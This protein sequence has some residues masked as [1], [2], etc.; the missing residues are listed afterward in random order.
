MS[1]RH[2]NWILQWGVSVS[3]LPQVVISSRLNKWVLTF[4]FRP[5]TS[6]VI[7]LKGEAWLHTWGARTPRLTRRVA[8]WVTRGL[9]GQELRRWAGSGSITSAGIT[10]LNRGPA[11]LVRP[12]QFDYTRWGYPL[13]GVRSHP[14][15]RVALEGEDH[16]LRP[17]YV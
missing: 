1:T 2:T 16:L 13:R 6:V 3:R 12:P 9:V 4:H 11:W 17:R 15:W 5:A 8:K 7:L 10:G 14:G